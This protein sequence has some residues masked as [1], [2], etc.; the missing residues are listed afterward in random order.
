MP[1]Y[2][3]I[4]DIMDFAPSKSEAVAIWMCGGFNTRNAIWRSEIVNRKIDIELVDSSGY[5]V[6]EAVLNSAYQSDTI[7]EPWRLNHETLWKFTSNIQGILKFLYIFPNSEDKSRLDSLKDIDAL[8]IRCLNV[9]QKNTIKSVSFI[10]I[11]AYSSTD[12]ANND[13]NDIASANQMIESIKNWLN[14]N[15]SEMEVYLVDRQ[16]GFN[17]L[18]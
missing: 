7:N 4:G 8:I 1:I 10:L 2:T 14:N 9:L 17:V 18:L 11:P 13:I 6:A 15:N 3:A 12:T 16:D 5:P